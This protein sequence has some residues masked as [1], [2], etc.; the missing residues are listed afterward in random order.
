MF[1]EVRETEKDLISKFEIN[2]YPTILV[3]TDPEKMIGTKYE[4]T[5][6]KD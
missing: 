2:S 4:G 1:G 3:L 6:K 5:F